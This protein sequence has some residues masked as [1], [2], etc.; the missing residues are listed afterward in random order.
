MQ[1]Q[2]RTGLSR[3]ERAGSAARPARLPDAYRT[4]RE[5]ADYL[6]SRGYPISFSTLTKLCA[7]G[8]GPEPAAWWGPRPLYTDPGL[9]LWAE[10]RCRRGRKARPSVGAQFV[11][12]TK[13]VAPGSPAAMP[14]ADS[15]KHEQAASTR[16][17]GDDC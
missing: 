10:S 17:P 12:P 7:L 11:I 9:D 5:A 13:S 4:R 16:E 14:T 1:S 8:E 3:E 6:R 2:S 15:G